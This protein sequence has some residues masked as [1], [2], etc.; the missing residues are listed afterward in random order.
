MV[1]SLTGVQTAAEELAADEGT[2]VQVTVAFDVEI[3]EVGEVTASL[4]LRLPRQGATNAA[5]LVATTVP[6][7]VADTVTEEF[8]V[9]SLDTL[10]H[11]VAVE[12]QHGLTTAAGTRHCLM[13]GRT[14]ASVTTER[15]FVTTRAGLRARLPTCWDRRLA[16]RTRI[17][18]KLGERGRTAGASRDDDGR[19]GTRRWRNRMRV[20]ALGTRVYTAL[21]HLAAR[22]LTGE[23]ANPLLILRRTQFLILQIP[24]ARDDLLV[25]TTIAAHGLDLVTGRARTEVT[26]LITLVL[27][28]VAL[29]RARLVADSSQS[30]IV[31][32]SRRALDSQSRAVAGTLDD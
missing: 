3:G 12:L 19:S 18:W 26:Q 1:G 29:L 20:A 15:A 31:R 22:A 6:E 11:L 30:S 10:A 14:G 23:S 28:T 8:G 21:V 4:A 17:P 13:T 9:P 27:A 24:A 16:V 2:F 5:A 32:V 7:G 25:L